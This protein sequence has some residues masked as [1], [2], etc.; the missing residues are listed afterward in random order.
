[1]NWPIFEVIFSRRS[2]SLFLLIGAFSFIDSLPLDEL[3]SLFFCYNGVTLTTPQDATNLVDYQSS[4]RFSYCSHD[5]FI[6][7]NVYHRRQLAHFVSQTSATVAH[8]T[9][10]LVVD[11]YATIRRSMRRTAA[12]VTRVR[13]VHIKRD[14]DVHSPQNQITT[15]IVLLV[16]LSLSRAH[17]LITQKQNRKLIL[18][19]LRIH[20]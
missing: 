11:S 6:G 3:L 17:L 1:M 5:V 15:N 14:V 8:D 12:V 9:R 10:L 2:L 18:F 7:S 16:F 13:R 4:N 20:I 19:F